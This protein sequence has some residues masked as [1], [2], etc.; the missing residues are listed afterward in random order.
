MELIEFV[1]QS[2]DSEVLVKI[3]DI[4]EFIKKSFEKL[5]KMA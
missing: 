1:E 5:E 4:S 3:E 2:N